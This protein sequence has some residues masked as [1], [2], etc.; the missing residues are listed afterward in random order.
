MSLRRCRYAVSEACDPA[1]VRRLVATIRVEDHVEE[2]SI[3][4]GSARNGRRRRVRYERHS[5]GYVTA[6]V[7]HVVWTGVTEVV[8]ETFQPARWSPE[9]LID[10]KI[11]DD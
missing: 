4:E 5:D 9:K 2:I 10:I 1:L 7:D 11:Y 8:V 6:I 3:D